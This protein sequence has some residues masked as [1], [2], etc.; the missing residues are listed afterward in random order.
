MS[1]ISGNRLN[2]TGVDATTP[3]EFK[4]YKRNP[5][6][7]EKYL[8]ALGTIVLNEVNKNIWMLVSNAIDNHS[9][10]IRLAPST[11]TDTFPCN[12]GTAIAEADIMQV[13][14]DDV[15]VRTYA[16]PDGSNLIKIKLKDD[17]SLIGNLTINSLTSG[18]IRS[19]AAGL[20]SNIA[21]GGKGELLIASDTGAPVWAVLDSSDGS[22]DII[23]GDNTIEL[24]AV[25]GGAG[26]VN[27]ME[28]DDGNVAI[29]VAGII[30]LLGGTNINTSA[31]TNIVTINLKDDVT[32][33]GYLHAGTDIESTNNVTISAGDLTISSLGEGIV[34]ADA[35]GKFS[36]SN[37]TNGQIYVA[38]TG[39]PAAWT[40]VTSGDGS[41]TV[42]E[43]P[44]TL[45]LT[46]TGGGGGA[47]DE[48]EAED[49]NLATPVAGVV[50]MYG[51]LTSIVTTAVGDTVT[52]SLKPDVT[53]A[54]SLT[55]TPLQGT[56]YAA[57]GGTITGLQGNDG[58]FYVGVTA[59]EGEWLT[60]VSE[61]GTVTITPGTAPGT[62]NFQSLLGPS[63]GVYTLSADV[64]GAVPDVAG[65][66]EIKG[67]DN[68][69]TD[70]STAATVIVNLDKSIY[71]PDTNASGVEGC[72]FLDSKRF[73]HNYGGSSGVYNTFVGEEAGEISL[74]TG[75]P[76]GNTGGG[77]RSMNKLRNGNYNTAFGYSTMSQ[78]T[79]YGSYNIALGYKAGYGYIAGTEDSNILI[80]NQGTSGEL[81][82]IR[83]GTQGT[84]NAQQDSCYIAGIKDGGSLD[85]TC[86]EPVLVD[87]Y[88][89]LSTNV[90]SQDGELLIGKT[91]VG[92]V[93]NTL[94]SS[95]GSIDIANGAG[96]IDLTIAIGSLPSFFAYQTISVAN[97]TGDG[98]IYELGTQS[99]F[100]EVFDTGNNFYPGDGA[101]ARCVFTAPETGKYYF[102]A[103][104]LVS[105][106]VPPA[107]PAPTGCGDPLLVITT[108]RTYQLINPVLGM[109]NYQSVLYSCLADMDLGDT[110]RFS[111]GA[112]TIYGT[113]TLGISS[114]NTRLSG[115]LVARG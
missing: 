45:D 43:G 73:L 97:V 8:Y 27:S 84:G 90:A 96:T 60:P 34:A 26:T 14:G 101:G 47:L 85:A 28:A 88:G 16:D 109:S 31:A 57:A 110:A 38:A 64:G 103:E 10:W 41:V 68:I 61:D 6:E 15:N 82:T 95:D 72:Y 32:L 83:I 67:G 79:S 87:Q 56:L 40:N 112:I 5:V 4:K 3:P 62:L 99:C 111:Y 74:Y 69:N 11:N 89:H 59:A 53:V 18:L 19:D 20:L 29:P 55:V 42:V 36:S 65:D 115:F 17:I 46:A 76:I 105:G 50:K 54:T 75:S 39:L 93:K 66:I 44:N 71:Q 108:K 25:G 33:A 94:S 13:K 114:Y 22:V 2:Y 7:K 51:D 30:E 104:V 35:T 113:R 81:H 100:T 37:G 80:G 77:Y 106:L 49:G 23:K 58:Q 9:P 107:P 63:S 21:D 86:I 98:T 48:L 1:R 102:T 92:M 12:V 78:A 52:V 70:A 91:G 24:K